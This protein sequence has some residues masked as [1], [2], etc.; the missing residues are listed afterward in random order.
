VF[1]FAGLTH[2]ARHIG[3]G[4]LSRLAFRASFPDPSMIDRGG[5]QDAIACPQPLLIDSVQYTHGTKTTA[6]QPFSDD[7]L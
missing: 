7:G 6:C 1:A 4:G 2:F 5:I 3:D